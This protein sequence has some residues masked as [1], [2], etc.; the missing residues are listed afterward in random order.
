MSKAAI[1]KNFGRN[2]ARV[3]VLLDI[4]DQNVVGGGPGRP[5][6]HM[7][8][9]LRACIVMLH[10]SF[11]DACRSIAAQRLPTAS[12]DV[13]AEIPF[14]G[15]KG[16]AK[17]VHLGELSSHRS[18]T[19]EQLIQESVAQYLEGFTVNNGPEIDAY[20][21]KIGIENPVAFRQ[22]LSFHALCGA[23]KRR[24][25]IVHQ[26]DKNP[27]GGRGHHAAQPLGR[28]TVEEWIAVV[29][30]FVLTLLETIWPRRR[31]R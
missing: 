3:R 22:P 19:V 14:T 5:G 12:S 26:A 24:H 7:S 4:Y 23:I 25:H 20:L 10:A 21:K 15:Q 9:I 30:Q 27:E 13:L 29:E 6:T 31:G 8:D 11:E 1:K 28:D 2:I 17:P 16:R 18:K